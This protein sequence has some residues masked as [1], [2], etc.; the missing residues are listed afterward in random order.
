MHHLSY[1]DPS[2]PSPE[3]RKSARIPVKR[4]GFLD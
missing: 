4:T 3:S 1:V 2:P